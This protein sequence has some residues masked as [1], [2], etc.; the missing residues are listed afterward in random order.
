MRI[1][2][3]NVIVA[4]AVNA[5]QQKKIDILREKY[6]L[7]TSKAIRVML[8][9]FTSK[10]RDYPGDE[11]PSPGMKQL[12]NCYLDD[13]TYRRMKALQEKWNVNAG[14]MVRAAINDYPIEMEVEVKE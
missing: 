13:E 7:D 11:P 3:S 1:K 8:V 6:E 2:K 9:R 14:F 12:T 5:E 4:P 10:K